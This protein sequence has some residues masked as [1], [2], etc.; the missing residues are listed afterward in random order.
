MPEIIERLE[1]AAVFEAD[2][3]R[4]EAAESPEAIK[5]I[6]QEMLKKL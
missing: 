6:A 2:Y 4:L 3:R 5:S 1:N